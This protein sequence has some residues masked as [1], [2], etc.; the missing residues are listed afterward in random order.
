MAGIILGFFG[1]VGAWSAAS[2]ARSVRQGRRTRHLIEGLQGADPAPVWVHDPMGRATQEVINGARTRSRPFLIAFDVARVSIYALHTDPPSP[3][4]FVP[5][6]L[7]WFGRPEKYA[8]GMNTLWLHVERSGTWHRIAL[9]LSRER[10]MAL[11]RALKAIATPEQVTAYRRRRPYIHV[12]PLP[13]HPASQDLLGAWTLE[14]ACALYL[15]PSHL[16]VLDGE[17]VAR[18]LPL[19]QLQK[20]SATRRLDQPGGAGLVRFECGTERLAFTLDDHEGFAASLAEAAKRTLE[21]PVAWERKKKKAIEPDDDEDW[22]D[23]D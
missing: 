20:I 3:F 15:M 8:S 5:A 4:T 22:L 7:R 18:A 19:E 9:R 10:M 1:A 2:V 14:P 21:D 11:V 13:A 12:G 17:R 6:E 16:V 23:E